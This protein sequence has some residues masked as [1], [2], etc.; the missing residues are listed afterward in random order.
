[1]IRHSGAGS[2]EITLTSRSASVRDD[3]CGPGWSDEP[4]VGNGLV[5]LR[6]RAAARG[7][8]VAVGP[9]PGGGYELTVCVGEPA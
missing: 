1:M 7:A 3:G 8:Q 2:C 4:I 5:G 6:E 9:V